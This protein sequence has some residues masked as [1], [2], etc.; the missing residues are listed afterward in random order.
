[1]IEKG[2]AF[3]WCDE[4]VVYEVVP[5]I[6]WKRTFMVRRAMLQ[7]AF[8][9]VVDPTFGARDFAKSFVA[10]SVYTAA[11]PVAL[12]LGHHRFMALVVKLFYHLGSLLAVLGINPIK[13]P[14]V[15]E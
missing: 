9:P 13:E 1:M 2:H 15:T 14:Y 8:V 5:P 7:G 6:R 12:V 3:I 10:V 4:A 11:L